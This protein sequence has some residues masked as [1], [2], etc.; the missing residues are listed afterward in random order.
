MTEDQLHGF[1]RSRR[2][3]ADEPY[4][5]VFAKPS[6]IATAEQSIIVAR[7]GGFLSEEFTGAVKSLFGSRDP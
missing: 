4:E 5:V 3:T 7:E 2:V 1:I 6:F